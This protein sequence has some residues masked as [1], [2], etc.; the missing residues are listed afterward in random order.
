[1]KGGVIPF[2]LHPANP[3]VDVRLRLVSGRLGH[4]GRVGLAGAIGGYLGDGIHAAY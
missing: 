3:L 4:L 1:M 2:A